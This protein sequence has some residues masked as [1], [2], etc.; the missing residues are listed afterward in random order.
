[1]K[2]QF[3]SLMLTVS[4]LSGACA[5]GIGNQPVDNGNT[6][7]TTGHPVL[8]IMN[9]YGVFKTGANYVAPYLVTLYAI[10][11]LRK[12]EKIPLVKS[13]IDWYLDHLNYPDKYGFT[14]S[15]YD[16]T[17]Y[18][19]GSEESLD[20][21]DSI[22]AYSAT[23]IML[24]KRY[25]DLTG[26]YAFVQS[27]RTTLEHI[28]YHVPSLM[29]DGYLTIAKPDYPVKY[30]MDNC[31]CY[32]GIMAFLALAE[33]FGWSSHSYYDQFDAPLRR[34]IKTH[35]YDASNSNYYFAIVDG[36]KKVSN[37]EPLY[38]GALA[39]LFPILY[40]IELDPSMRQLLWDRF[41]Q[42]YADAIYEETIEKQ[43]I[44]Q[45]TKEEM[46]Q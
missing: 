33:T 29:R 3:I 32:G 12:G 14:N 19:D 20:D 40:D 41:N 5:T 15:I 25:Y 7:P 21:M 45:W 44:Y 37:W 39:Q 16:Y 18:S 23:F 42:Y 4:I 24:V 43:I 38:P 2:K 31:E 28:I 27:N 10:D 1:M 17:I 11:L 6:T 30:L 35:L 34:A 13:Y 9:I 46:N 26:D 36:V 22:D 8:E